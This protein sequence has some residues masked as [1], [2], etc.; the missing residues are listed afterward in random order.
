MLTFHDI[1]MVFSKATTESLVVRIVDIN[2]NAPVFTEP[3]GY[4]FEVNEGQAGLAVGVVEV[5]RK[6][7]IVILW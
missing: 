2:D 5:C 3:M 7:Y 1:V 6:F 4:N